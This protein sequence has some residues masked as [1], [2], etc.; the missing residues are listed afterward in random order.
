M[1]DLELAVEAEP[2]VQISS[3]ARISL[4]VM[5]AAKASANKFPYIPD[6]ISEILVDDEYLY[7]IL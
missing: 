7:F 6:L 5:E 4:L 2:L 1:V 3:L